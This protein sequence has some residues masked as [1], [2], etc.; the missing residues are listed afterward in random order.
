MPSPSPNDPTSARELLAIVGG[1]L[2][3]LACCAGPALLAAG[4]LGALG[5]LLRNPV[6]V[7][8]AV[9]LVGAAVGAVALR[10]AARP[11][12][13]RPGRPRAANPAASNP[14]GPGR[15]ERGGSANP[16]DRKE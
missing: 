15:R 9:L 8:G 16:P 7:G 2:L 13:F 3:V 11:A 12:E 6:L 10:R 5:G 1:G 14:T 4:V